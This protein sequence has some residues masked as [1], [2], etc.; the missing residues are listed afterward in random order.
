MS[1]RMP[2]AI[3]AATFVVALFSAG[4][5]SSGGSKA[6]FCSLWKTYNTQFK[7][8]ASL[9]DLGKLQGAIG[10][11]VAA[12]PAE[13]KADAV[14]VKTAFDAV[15][16]AGNDPAKQAAAAQKLTS[17]KDVTDAGNRLEAYTTKNCK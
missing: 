12:A 10:N 6:S 16:A 4:C 8:A 17:G 11:L 1:T 2:K 14:K 9:K 7:D 15:V 13:I 5:S 3:V